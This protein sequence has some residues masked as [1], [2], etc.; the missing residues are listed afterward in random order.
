MS[1]GPPGGL[2]TAMAPSL[3]LPFRYF[4][5]SLIFLALFGLLIPFQGELLLGGYFVPRLL[6]LVHIVT[7]GWV[8]TPS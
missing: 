8:V 2:G 7:L 3:S 1:Y 6:A 4:V 5:A